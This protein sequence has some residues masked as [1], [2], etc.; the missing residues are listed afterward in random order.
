MA[1]EPSPELIALTLSFLDREELVKYVTISRSW[2]YAVERWT[3]QTI[4]LKS[5]DLDVFRDIVVGHRRATL[6]D[7]SYDVILPT[8][9]DHRCARFETEED[10]RDN[11]EAL[12][13]AIHGIFS[14]L[15]SWNQGTAHGKGISKQTR[16]ISF[17]L[18]AY[19][20]M[21]VDHRENVDVEDQRFQAQLAGGRKDLFEHR[22]EHSFLR[23]LRLA[24]LP[25]LLQVTSFYAEELCYSRRI[26]GASLA[27]I[28]AKSPNLERIVW[29]VNDNE[30]RYPDVRR[31][32]RY[33]NSNSANPVLHHLLMHS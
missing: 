9:S 25:V 10:K 31:L 18:N 21:D 33:G 15:H 2:Q 8:Y 32:H 16:S 19:S 20:P 17:K 1:F 22:Y 14:I 28:A 30:K 27:G 11:N 13:E 6:A 26:E 12:T 23:V 29:A 3:F 5:T 4:H 24:E 7:L